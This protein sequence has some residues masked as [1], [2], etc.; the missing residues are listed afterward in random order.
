MPEQFPILQRCPG[1]DC[2]P[3]SFSSLFSSP[4]LSRSARLKERHH[5]EKVARARIAT[6]KAELTVGALAR[7][8][9]ACREQRVWQYS[10]A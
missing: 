1:R 5:K 10:I 3:F 6:A 7:D 4:C 9:S 2:P 8:L